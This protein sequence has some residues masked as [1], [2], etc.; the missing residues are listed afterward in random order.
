M[1]H[2]SAFYSRFSPAV[3]AS[4]VATAFLPI[5]SPALTSFNGDYL[6]SELTFKKCLSQ[7]ELDALRGT[8]GGYEAFLKCKAEAKQLA[9]VGYKSTLKKLKAAGGKTALKEFHTAFMTR[10]ESSEAKDGELAIQYNNRMA[11]LDEKVETAQ[12]KLLL[13][14]PR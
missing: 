12:Q 14:L 6:L 4:I 11:A 9:D 2:N 8:S 1:K 10:I 13:E 5:A 3:R 7:A